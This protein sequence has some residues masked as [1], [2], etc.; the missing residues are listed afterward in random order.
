MA[1]IGIDA[2]LKATAI[3]GD[4]DIAVVACGKPA[5]SLAGR[6]ARYHDSLTRIVDAVDLLSVSPP[7]A[8]VCFLENYFIARATQ[9]AIHIIEH[10]MALRLAL[11]TH[12]VTVVEVAPTVLKKF[13]AGNGNANKATMISTLSRKYD[14]TFASDDEADAYG[15]WRLGRCVVGIDKATNADQRTAVDDVRLLLKMEQ[16]ERE[17][18]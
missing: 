18:T 2:S 14:V 16:Q 5:K 4:D 1:V 15:L 13:V 8:T 10:G 7:K 17:A 9:T 12:G 3:C 11:S 6:L